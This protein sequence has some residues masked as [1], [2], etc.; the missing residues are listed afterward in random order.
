MTTKLTTILSQL[1]TAGISEDALIIAIKSVITDYELK[2]N[3]EQTLGVD[4]ATAI[5]LAVA[6]K[7]CE[8][9]NYPIEPYWV[10]PDLPALDF[11]AWVANNIDKLD[12]EDIGSVLLGSLRLLFEQAPMLLPPQQKPK[13]LLPRN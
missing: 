3:I 9:A 1:K 8:A 12:R 7:L 13:R 6:H 10:N 2:E 4:H 11:G 5:Q